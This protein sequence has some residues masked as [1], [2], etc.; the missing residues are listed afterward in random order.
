MN[1]KLNIMFFYDVIIK[2][3]TVNAALFILLFYQTFE[4]F[5][6]VSLNI[7]PNRLSHKVHAIPIKVFRY[8]S[9]WLVQN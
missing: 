3:L 5:I 9:Y 4:F 2:I 6:F 7:F 1:A 8:H